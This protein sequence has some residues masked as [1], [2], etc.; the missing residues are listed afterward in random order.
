MAE[1]YQSTHNV[2]VITLNCQGLRSPDNRDTLFSWL[3]C[4]N[5]DFLCL[6]ETHSTLWK[7]FS[8]WLKT[9]IEDGLLTNSYSCFSSPGT[10]RSGG[11][12]IIY[13]NRDALSSC[14]ADQ[15]GRLLCTQFTLENNLF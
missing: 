4:T 13:N 12:A 6:Q 1:K 2:E 14:H 3:N 15:Q 7:E 10:N 9:A 5:V 8:S 11:V